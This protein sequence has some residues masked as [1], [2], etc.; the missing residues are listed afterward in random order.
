LVQTIATLKGWDVGARKD[1]GDKLKKTIIAKSYLFDPQDFGKRTIDL[2]LRLL[3]TGAV[4]CSRARSNSMALTGSAGGAV[5]IRRGFI[6]ASQSSM[7][8]L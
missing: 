4:R 3:Y 6:A 1:R 8:A 2:R 7:A 5:K